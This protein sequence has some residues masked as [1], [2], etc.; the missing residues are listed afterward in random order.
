MG[1]GRLELPTSRLSGVRSNH[2]SYRPQEPEKLIISG[3]LL[4]RITLLFPRWCR[5]VVSIHPQCFLIRLLDVVG[6]RIVIN[7][8]Q[9]LEA[10][11]LIARIR[12]YVTTGC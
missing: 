2:P 7:V 10:L 9:C 12:A 5:F 1:L 11:S 3:I 6:S 4:N 8:P